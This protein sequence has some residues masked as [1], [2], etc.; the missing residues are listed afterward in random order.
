VPAPVDLGEGDPG[1]SVAGRETAGFF[2]IGLGG[3][4]VTALEGEESGAVGFVEGAGGK[5]E[6]REEQLLGSGR[7]FFELIE[8]GF[9]LG[10]VGGV[11]CE[12]EVLGQFGDGAGVI[13][14]FGED[15]PE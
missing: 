12:F 3:G 11:G 9:D 8:L 13:F 10:L 6:E 15:E 2:E 14:L 5:E 1:A 7:E 4:E